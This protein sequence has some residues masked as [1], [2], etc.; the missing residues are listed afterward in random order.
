M[1]NILRI[2]LKSRKCN[3]TQ[4]YLFLDIIF[5]IM[6][7]SFVQCGFNSTQQAYTGPPQTCNLCNDETANTSS[8]MCTANLIG[9]G[10]FGAMPNLI[11]YETNSI[12]VVV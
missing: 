9:R 1:Q 8:A 11:G 7:P 5:I 10:S 12:P 2:L 6:W 4:L 3:F